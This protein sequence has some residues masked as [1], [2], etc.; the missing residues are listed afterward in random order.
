MFIVQCHFYV[1][2]LHLATR[3]PY[4]GTT[5]IT[6]LLLIP[7]ALQLDKWHGHVLCKWN[8]RFEASINLYSTKSLKSRFS[9]ARCID[10]FRIYESHAF[11]ETGFESL[12]LKLLKE[13]SFASHLIKNDSF[14]TSILQTH[15]KIRIGTCSGVCVCFSFYFSM[16]NFFSRTEIRN[17]L[18]DIVRFFFATAKN[19]LLLILLCKISRL[20]DIVE[21]AGWQRSMLKS[22]VC[23]IVAIRCHISDI[24]SLNALS[25]ERSIFPTKFPLKAMHAF[26]YRSWL[27]TTVADRK[28]KWWK[29]A[30]VDRKSIL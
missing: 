7:N 25:F 17:T 16:V 15:K 20:I 1:K 12:H 2:C 5:S 23:L 29:T 14:L 21:I 26:D 30:N 28:K 4:H 19:F 22:N 8:S 3:F 24:F 6:N 10:G 18:L 11:I 27:G 9:F 13:A